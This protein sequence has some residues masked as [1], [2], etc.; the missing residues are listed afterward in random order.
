M[1]GLVP[2]RIVYFVF[3]QE[4]VE[5]LAAQRAI[6]SSHVFAGEPVTVG[7]VKPA[8][9][10][11][12]ADYGGF[13]NLKVHL[14]GPDDYWARDVAFEKQEATNNGHTWHWMFD[15]QVGRYD[16]AAKSH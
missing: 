4:D 15:G 9:V 7:E 6:A 13:V 16:A 3:G 12:V 5:Q 14:D 8:M 2:G 1:N 10:V 11:K